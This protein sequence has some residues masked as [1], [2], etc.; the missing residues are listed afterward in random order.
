M[1]QVLRVM[2]DLYISGHASKR[3]ACAA[4]SAAVQT[5]ALAACMV[6][7]IE[8]R[9]L[10]DDVAEHGGEAVIHMEEIR[11][12]QGLNVISALVAVLRKQAEAF[13]GEIDIRI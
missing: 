7:G 2:D 8:Y 10:M 9:R 11:T 5:A 12:K 4:V 6:D 1:I 3:E 13:A